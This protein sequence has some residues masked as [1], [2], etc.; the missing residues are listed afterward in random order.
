MARSTY[1]YH[2]ANLD[3]G[4][5]DESLKLHI[6]RIYTQ[7]SGCYGYRRI[8]LQLQNEGMNVNHKAVQR[9]MRDMG[10]KAVMKRSKYRSYKGEVGKIAPNIIA[11]DFTA[12]HSNQKWATDIT[13]YKINDEKGYLSP[14]LDMYNGEIVA[15]GLSRHPDLQLVMGMVDMA[16]ETARP[17]AGLIIHSDQGWHYQ[18]AMYRNRLRDAG[19]VQSMSRK[20]N[21]LDNSMMENFFGLMKNE[22]LYL[23]RWHS[24]EEF[25]EALVKYIDYYNNS[26]IKLRLNGMSPVQYRLNNE[27]ITVNPSNF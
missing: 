16:L 25:E 4:D 23:Y 9:L 10:L 17:E 21:C 13:E 1:Y 20:G 22:L 11:R 14:I 26:R 18:H 24:I 15:Y 27:R 2:A 12:T 6:M 19:I 3:E 8:T 5:R 7:H